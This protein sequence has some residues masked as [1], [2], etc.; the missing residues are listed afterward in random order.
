M[1]NL[2][3]FFNK[4]KKSIISL[5]L[6]AVLALSFNYSPIALL[7]DIFKTNAYKSNSVQNYYS[8]STTTE[9]N[10]TKNYPTE[11]A[12]YFKN[13]DANFNIESYYNDR[14]L[15]LFAGYVHSY[16]SSID[17]VKNIDQEVYNTLY[18]AFLATEDKDT[19]FEYYTQEK[20]NIDKDG[21]GTTFQEYV[22]YFM[23]HETTFGSEGSQKT[24]PALFAFDKDDYAYKSE[25]YCAL[26]NYFN[27]LENNGKHDAVE[28]VEVENADGE[29]VFAKDGVLS[30]DKFYA[31]SVS[32]KKVKT[33]I[34]NEIKE[35]VAIYTYDG[36]TQNK[37]VA[38]IIANEAPVS[39]SYYY[40]TNEYKDV[41]RTTYS[42]ETDSTT[43]NNKVYVIGSKDDNNLV[44]ALTSAGIQNTDKAVGYITQE[45]FENNHYIYIPIKQGQTGYLANYLTYY[46]YSSV[47]FEKHKNSSS[48]DYKVFVIDKDGIISA[49]EQATYDFMY[50]TVLSKAEYEKNPG[51]YANI[52]VPN[53]TNGDNEI[54]FRTVSGITPSSDAE[55]ERFN[56]FKSMFIDDSGN[57]ILYYQYSTSEDKVVY[58]DDSKYDDFV[59]KNSTYAYKHTLTEFDY[60]TCNKEEYYEVQ[61][62]D[63][64]G[65]TVAGYKLYFKKEIAYYETLTSATY[66]TK[67]GSFVYETQKV[68]N[69]PYEQVKVPTTEYETVSENDLTKI[70]Y[71][72]V[73]TNGTPHPD[74]DAKFEDLYQTDLDKE[75]SQYVYN[76]F[77]KVP[78]AIAAEYNKDLETPYEY[79]YRHKT[80]A[81]NKIYIVI[82]DDKFDAEKNNEVYKN[83]NYTV[84]S[85]SDYSNTYSGYISVEK[86]DPNYNENFKLYYRYNSATQNGSEY[87]KNSITGKP[88]KFIIDD[89]VSSGDKS[90]YKNIDRNFVVI[91]TAE[92]EANYNFYIQIT[93]DNEVYTGDYNLKYNKLYYKYN[94]K[95]Q[96]EKVVYTYSS[97][98]DNTYKSFYETDEDYLASDYELIEYG[99][100]NYVEGKNLYYKK[101]RSTAENSEVYT[102]EPKVTTFNYS[103]SSTISLSANSY[104]VVSFYV[105][106]SGGYTYADDNTSDDVY[107][108]ILPMQASFYAVDSKGNI[109]D[110]KIEHISTNGTW[111]KHYLFIKTN[112]LLSSS[113][114]LELHMG[115][116]T[117]IFGT[118]KED[119]TYTM[120]TGSVLF[121]DIRV[122]KINETDYT[123]TRIDDEKVL[124]KT[125]QDE[126]KENVLDD[127][128]NVIYIDEYDNRIFAH[129]PIESV[130]DEITIWNDKTFDEMFN[131]DNMTDYFSALNESI[132]TADS[133]DGNTIPTDL[134]QMYISRDVTGP[135]NNKQL[136]RYQNAYKEGQLSI[137]VVDESSFFA[138]KAPEEDDDDDAI[139]SDAPTEE[140][141]DKAYIES[142][143]KDD[144]K[145]LKLANSSRQLT[146]GLISNYFEIKQNEY[147]KLTVWIYATDEDAKATLS[148]NSILYTAS[149]PTYGSLLSTTANVDAHINK[150]DSSKQTN[151]YGWIPISFYIEGNALH[152]Q[153][154]YLTLQ[155]DGD[156]TIYFD[157]IKIE[158]ITSSSYDTANSDSDKTTY[159]L[160]LTPSTAVLSAGVTN[161]YFNNV[162]V[163]SN[164][165]GTI[166]Y[167]A[168]RTAESWTVYKT[169]E[170]IIAGV[171]PTSSIYTDKGVNTF[172]GKYN[173]TS[174]SYSIP[175]TTL[176]N[177]IYAIYAP[178]T[179]N[180]PLDKNDVETYDVRNTYSIHSTSISLS[181]STTYKLTFDFYNGY[182]FNGNIFANIYTSSVKAENLIA[183]LTDNYTT[184]DENGWTTYT[185]YISTDASSTTVYIELGIDNAYGTCFFKDV[186]NV[187]TTETIDQIRDEIITDAENTDKT[188]TDI[189]EKDSLKNIKFIELNAFEFSLVSGE[190]DANS[191]TYVTNEFKN[192][193]KDTS[194]F[195][196]GDTAIAVATYYTSSTSK[197]YTVTI[198]KVE[199]Y[200]KSFTDNTTG[201]TTYKM[202]SDS[203]YTDE[204]TKLDGK[205]VTVE[206]LNK[207]IIGSENPTEYTT[208][209]KE[210]TNYEYNFENDLTINNVF[211][212]ADELKNT[213]SE[214]VLILANSYSSDYTLATPKY[215][216]TLNKTSYYVLKI[217]AKT[218]SFEEGFGLNIDLDST[219]SRKWTNLDTTD[220]KYNELR[221]ENGFVCYQIL[222]STNTNAISSFN[223]KF[224]LGTDKST[225]SGYAIIAGIELENF[226]T[227]K[228][229]NEYALNYENINKDSNDT[230]IKSYIGAITSAT[231]TS[232][233]SDSTTDKTEDDTTSNWATFF[234]IFS[235]LLLG[236]VLVMALVAII[237]KKHPIKVVKQEQNDHERDNNFV[238]EAKKTPSK[239]K[240]DKINSETTETEETTEDV[241]KKDDG[242]I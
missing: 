123:K 38:G 241:I 40:K 93:S 103:T 83:L 18:S 215:S 177:N 130:E 128:G 170:G 129:S 161:G 142:T 113:I 5:A 77:V 185:F 134:W 9:K 101:V 171:V 221:D 207:V 78:D 126:N 124:S 176:K 169:S 32:Y 204:V 213:I 59:A 29:K 121:D 100:P 146:L 156:S 23:S 63:F 140:D 173:G 236:I 203:N 15:D 228:L 111:Q 41:T 127:G 65:Y 133:V 214:N 216:T 66:E 19:L 45:T 122:I 70:V 14:Y 183:T 179:I 149:T 190:K 74:P 238:T 10:F 43:G 226:A 163:S 2:K 117:S 141:E 89:S 189:N 11:L 116:N 220:A 86:D 60:D 155:A 48:T 201:V 240:K 112:S 180:H 87:V 159:C 6:A 84:I 148:V 143:F 105:N 56:N 47:P 242:F 71:A 17:N 119:N 67:D 28:N 80:T 12:D 158:K 175:A 225:G 165:N 234:Y 51:Y 154:C 109:S 22:E 178:Q 37:N 188:G 160:S 96:Q 208:V 132:K 230:I 97:K 239:K 202:F 98:S 147:Y 222:I 104:Y 217:Y 54:Y 39:K 174:G 120:A 136:E 150:Y 69:I 110:V 53:G 187:S 81:K 235:S 118:V 153:N 210:K 61:S 85:N 182:N 200:L 49:D 88:A 114:K 167:I 91:T 237:I 36:K 211:I 224:S 229:F 26:S 191:N 151:E 212:D 144:N 139:D 107:P 164:Y 102:K 55:I 137:S 99:D 231:D 205:I 199:Y 44:A 7:S 73:P 8:S 20:K 135:G 131:F 33:Y 232:G 13:S 92:Y 233:S 198:N 181:A 197:S 27:K 34:D 194:T 168:P 64:G 68:P 192:D 25:F 115:D 82:S 196:T 184:T 31:E 52:P 157:N 138:D 152:N 166:D 90:D 62:S 42:I 162:T 223:V 193:L 94:A 58:I 206:S 95:D 106:T 218:S 125:R 46:K 21:K 145:V 76:E 219:I 50:F 30:A 16:F 24:I 195:T 1:N 72:L 227:E 186:A 108:T 57:S 35:T 172:F 3:K 75:D 4:K 209:E 79:Y